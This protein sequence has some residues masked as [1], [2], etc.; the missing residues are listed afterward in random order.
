M[1]VAETPT[2]ESIARNPQQ[3]LAV[4]SAI[5][6]VAILACLWIVFAGLPELWGRVWAQIFTDNL[7]LKRNVFLSDALLILIDLLLIGGLGFATFRIFQQ[8]AQTGLRAGIF[9]GAIYLFAVLALC[10]W[11]SGLMQ[12]Q[13]QDNP[14]V[15]WAVLG[16]VFAAP[17]GGAGY[18]YLAGSGWMNFLGTV[19]HQGWFDGRSYKANQGVRV[20][21][22][23]ILGFIAVGACGIIT[24][25]QHRFF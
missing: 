8:Q 20:R 21:R 4:G 13:F 17:L 15:G 23:T 25:I 10:G 24:L 19:E 1:S 22:G 14:P 5:G 6:A 11:L 3:Q 18:V 16:I 12:D 7:D 2:T 9:F